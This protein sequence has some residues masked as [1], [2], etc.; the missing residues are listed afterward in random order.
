MAGQKIRI[1]NTLHAKTGVEPTSSSSG[2]QNSK[3]RSIFDMSDGSVPVLTP[4]SPLINLLSKM[5]TNQRR[6]IQKIQLNI[7]LGY[8]TNQVFDDADDLY[9]WLSP[10]ERLISGAQ[11]PAE[12]HR[13]KWFRVDLPASFVF[14]FAQSVADAESMNHLVGV[15]DF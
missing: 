14:Q 12:A 6:G 9:R 8:S 3:R 5:T 4:E 7:S 2:E 1:P 11:W 15:A 13:K 10:G